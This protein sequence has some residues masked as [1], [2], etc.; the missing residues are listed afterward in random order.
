MLGA[1]DFV[2]E[3]AQRDVGKRGLGRR[4]VLARLFRGVNLGRKP[5]GVIDET[6]IHHCAEEGK[7]PVANELSPTKRLNRIACDL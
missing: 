6:S 5:R 2:N 7:R 1:E 4:V 3:E